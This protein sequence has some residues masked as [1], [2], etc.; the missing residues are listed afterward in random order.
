M[1]SNYLK[2]LDVARER[3]GVD[4]R[5]TEEYM[6]AINARH[7][8]RMEFA[9]FMSFVE[10]MAEREIKWN[11]DMAFC[12]TDNTYSYLKVM[13]MYQMWLDP[14]PDPP[15][16]SPS[17][18]KA[19]VF[20]DD[21]A[22]FT[23]E[24]S[25]TRDQYCRRTPIYSAGKHACSSKEGWLNTSESRSK[26]RSLLQCKLFI[27]ESRADIADADISHRNANYVGLLYTYAYH[28]EVINHI[29]EDI[30][31]ATDKNQAM[32]QLNASDAI[33]LLNPENMSPHGKK[34]VTFKEVR[35][36]CFEDDETPVIKLPS[37]S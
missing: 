22:D 5:E 29:A 14:R 16:I 20:V 13:Q 33:L 30:K 12:S 37:L 2:F 26:T 10:G 3:M 15:R 4:E 19:V 27:A 7:F 25:R 28:S 31:K 11:K 32:E 21:T 9:N 35:L 18:A 17:P 24:K 36:F 6:Q 34:Y 23:V 1:H 8:A